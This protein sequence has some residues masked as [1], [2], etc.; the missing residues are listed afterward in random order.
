MQH[1]AQA[2]PRSAVWYIDTPDALFM[3][4]DRVAMRNNSGDFVPP[5]LSQLSRQ[6]ASISLVGMDVTGVPLLRGLRQWQAQ[7]SAE[8][9][10]RL[11]QVVLLYPSLYVNTPVA[12]RER[13]L[14]AYRHAVGQRYRFFSY[15]DAMFL[16]PAAEARECE[17]RA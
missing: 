8:D 5:V 3:E 17:A 7:A 10:A 16:E 9:R 12:G 11:S 14:E 13:V 2:N 6:F 1:L 4:R 15:G